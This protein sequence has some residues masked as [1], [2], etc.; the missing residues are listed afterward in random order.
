MKKRPPQAHD[1]EQ[2][3]QSPRLELNRRQ[4]ALVES[5]ILGRLRPSALVVL[6]Y[7]IAHADFAQCTVYLGARTIAAAAFNG[8][9]HRTTARRGIADLIEAGILVTVTDRTYRK[10][11]V[12]RITAPSDRAQGCALSGHKA[13]PSQGTGLSPEGAQGCAPNPA[14]HASH[15]SMRG[16]RPRA[17]A[18]GDAHDKQKAR[19]QG[20]RI[21]PK[22][23]GL[24]AKECTAEKS[25][26]RKG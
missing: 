12:Y 13:E 21:T 24:L 9:K 20:L 6:H 16:M 10:A 7:A 25:L 19:L 3:E 22:A 5:G 11:T 23:S 18:Q 15:R 8:S 26:S 4:R 14:S 17:N 2:G 1:G